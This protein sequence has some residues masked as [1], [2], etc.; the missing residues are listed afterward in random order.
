MANRIKKHERPTTQLI[1]LDDGA[2]YSYL[3][4]YE[5]YHKKTIQH[6]TK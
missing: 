3:E 4:N 1:E 5:S 2:Y 6:D